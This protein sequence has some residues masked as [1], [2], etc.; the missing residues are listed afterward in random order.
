M[1]EWRRASIG[2]IV[3]A[4]RTYLVSETGLDDSR[5]VVT[6][7]PRESVPRLAA[8]QDLLIRVLG[9]TPDTPVIDGAG[10]HDNRRH[11]TLEVT[12]RTRVS[13][14]RLDQDLVRLTDESLGHLALEDM[15]ADALELYHL[16]DG[17]DVMA[18]PLRVMQLT[19]PERLQTDKHWIAS[20]FTVALTYRR[21]MDVT[22]W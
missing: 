17:P 19:A 9:E 10:R 11:R 3:L 1:G 6:A 21:D 4:L 13:L 18:A 12:P 5:V 20:S 7:L 15:V 2:E 22:R 16:E 14:D 8:A